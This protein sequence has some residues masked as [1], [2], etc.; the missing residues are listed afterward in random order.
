MTEVR[1]M[2]QYNID[3]F[4]LFFNLDKLNDIKILTVELIMLWR[5]KVE[6]QFVDMTLATPSFRY[7]DNVQTL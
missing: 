1:G 2:L 7:D 4:W 5:Q 3:N 6:K